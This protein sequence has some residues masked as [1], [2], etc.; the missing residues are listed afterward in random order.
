MELRDEGV[1]KYREHLE[2]VA[3]LQRAKE[4]AEVGGLGGWGVDM[5]LMIPTASW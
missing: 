4:R 3:E 5:G 1:T 2:A